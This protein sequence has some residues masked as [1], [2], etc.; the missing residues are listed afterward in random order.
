[1]I[2]DMNVC[3]SSNQQNARVK[4]EASKLIKLLEENKFKI[5]YEISNPK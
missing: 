4:Q 5:L 2:L 1:M 3:I